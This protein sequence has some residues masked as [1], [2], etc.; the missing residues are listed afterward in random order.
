MALDFLGIRMHLQRRRTLLRLRA[1]LALLNM[2]R[3]IVTKLGSETTQSEQFAAEWAVHD[4][5]AGEQWKSVHRKAL[6]T[7]VGLALSQWGGMEDLL[8]GIASLLLRTHEA[9]K[10]GIIFYSITNPNTW[11]S[12]IGELFSQEPRYI[13]LKP[14][15]NKLSERLIKLN[16]TRVRLAHHTIYYGD[17]ATTIA[18][19]TSLRPGQFDVRPK[20]QKHRFEPLDHD[21]ISKFIDSVGKLVA[22][23]TELLNAMTALLTQETSQ[24]KSSQPTT[25]QRHP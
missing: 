25:D 12:I 5:E 20:S 6:F 10:V 7:N 22:D 21:Q 18:G 9:T 16:D 24:Q 17:R 23:L 4:Q 19:D 3:P 15:W 13:A 1:Q 8:I 11:C 14:R 2:L